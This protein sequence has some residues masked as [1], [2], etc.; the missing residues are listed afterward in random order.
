MAKNTKSYDWS[1]PIAWVLLSAVSMYFAGFIRFYSVYFVN[2]LTTICLFASAQTLILI[3]LVNRPWRWLVVTV[4]GWYVAYLI[5]TLLYSL[6]LPD[7]V[8]TLSTGILIGLFTGIP[9]GLLLS[10]KLSNRIMWTVA[11][12]LGWTLP[13]AYL[14]AAESGLLGPQQEEWIWQGLYDTPLVSVWINS[15]IGLSVGFISGIVFAYL[16]Y[17]NWKAKRMLETVSSTENA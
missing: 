14:A 9:Q 15:F 10:S 6:N 3:Y 17:Q 2:W 8:Y 11:S 5:Q 4:G 7:S 16:L 13:F 12:L 1:L